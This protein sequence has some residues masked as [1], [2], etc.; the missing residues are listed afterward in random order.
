VACVTI[1]CVIVIRQ[2]RSEDRAFIESMAVEAV[3]WDPTRPALS[4][5]VI[6]AEP[7]FARYLTGWLRP[8][9]LG[10]VAEADGVAIGAAWLRFFQAC[11]PGYGFIAP[12]IPEISIGV[13]PSW[14]GQGIG[15]RLLERLIDLARARRVGAMSLSVEPANPAMR[16]YER[17]GFRP[18]ASDDDAVT[19][20]LDLD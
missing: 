15:G 11:E 20:R 6:A 18:V 13:R 10:V 14:R 19:M 9:D 1:C 5:E 16:L 12:E 7:T 8:D 3:N 17:H 2:A 4:P